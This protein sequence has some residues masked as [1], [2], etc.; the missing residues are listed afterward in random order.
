MK[1]LKKPEN[2]IFDTDNP[3]KIEINSD[4]VKS[5][6]PLHHSTSMTDWD[7]LSLYFKSKDENK[8]PI[9]MNF[10]ESYFYCLSV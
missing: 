9:F 5:S 10:G 1:I 8:H 3:E 7:F 6:I 2:I 4:H